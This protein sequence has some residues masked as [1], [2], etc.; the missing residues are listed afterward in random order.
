[1]SEARNRRTWNAGTAQT[2][3]QLI[4][5]RRSIRSYTNRP[6]RRGLIQRLLTAAIW[7]P[8]AHNRQPWRFAVIQDDAT[9]TRLADAMNAVLRADLAADGLPPDQIETHAA[10][11]RARLTRAP[12]LILLC[13]TMADMHDY[14]DEK[15]R[16]AEWVM[17]T[18]SLAL[19]GQNLLLAAHAEGLGACWLCAPLFCPGVVRDTLGLP[20]DWEP[21]AFISLGWPH[22]AP[23]KGREPPDTRIWFAT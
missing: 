12:V 2:L 5:E 20:P 9:K 4:R 23:A 22:E 21:Q 1:M 11:R 14:P 7:A 18:Q 10:R 13:I 17:A 3:Y 8:S 19:A 6:V 15:R 16:R